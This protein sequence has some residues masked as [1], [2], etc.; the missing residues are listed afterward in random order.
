[1][2]WVCFFLLYLNSNLKRTLSVFSCPQ[3]LVFVF[4]KSSKIHY[5]STLHLR[6]F[7]IFVFY[8]KKKT[9]FSE[10]KL[11]IFSGLCELVV[12]VAC[13]IYTTSF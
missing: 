10:K 1:M 9:Y 7:I 6:S 11:W 13:K 12:V 2:G 4:L 3:F 8:G 5:F